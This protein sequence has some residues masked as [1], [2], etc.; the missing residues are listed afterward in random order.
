[1]P[2]PTPQDYNEAIQNPRLCFA[3]PELR[4]GVPEVT[5]LG[6][7]RP[8]TG[9]FASVYRVRCGSRDWAVRCFWRET[10]DLGQRY[11]AISRHLA[12][13]RLPYT[14]GFDYLPQGICVRGAW[15]PILKME[16]VEGELL[17]TYVERHLGDASALADLIG[18]WLSMA[19]A[20]ERCSVA[21][22]DLQHGNVLVVGQQLKLVDYDCMYVPALAGRSSHELGHQNYQHPARTERHF[23]PYLDRFSAWVVYLALLAMRADPGLWSAIGGGDECLLLRRTDFEQ[24]NRSALLTSLQGHA[25][26]EVRAAAEQLLVA[27]AAAPDAIPPLYPVPSELTV[28]GGSELAGPLPRPLIALWTLLVPCPRRSRPEAQQQAASLPAWIRESEIFAQRLEPT[29]SHSQMRCRNV[30]LALSSVAAILW[31]WLT[32][33]Y[34]LPAW[35]SAGLALPL[36]AVLDFGVLL[37]LFRHEPAVVPSARSRQIGED[38]GESPRWE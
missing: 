5:P 6:L 17:S 8:V 13:Q 37:L 31:I 32:L 15:F 24:P 35:S 12:S 29:F 16:W 25:D 21:H 22:G 9:N 18:A 30:C 36:V 27:L 2:W 23:G 4:D 34:R 3:D 10:A 1:M 19:S 26:R 7:P 38:R 28:R 11:E 20:L 33:A 14:V